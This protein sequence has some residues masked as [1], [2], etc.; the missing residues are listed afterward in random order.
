[1]SSIKGRYAR[2]E[3]PLDEAEND[4]E[5]FLTGDY[6]SVVSITGEGTCVMKLDHRHSQ[7]LDF[8]EVSGITGL[9]ERLYFT[10]NGGGGIC[11]LFVG[12]GIA[13]NISPDPE[14]LWAGGAISTQITTTTD[15]VQGLAAVPLKLED[16]T[17]LNENALYACYVG[18]YNSVLATFKAHAYLLLPHKTFKFTKVDMYSLGTTSY[19]GTNNVIL[20]I[21]GRY[22]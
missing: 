1:M 5:L 4:K 15:T 19:D 9:F 22:Q 3:I 2:I 13:I 17:I 11:T 20:D 12:T 10:T 18:P 16:V 7:K 8:R 21:L 14:K 6:L